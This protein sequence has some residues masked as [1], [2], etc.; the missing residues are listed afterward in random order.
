[1][2]PFPKQGDSNTLFLTSIFSLGS[3]RVALE[4]SYALGTGSSLEQSA[5]A[6]QHNPLPSAI[7]HHLHAQE[8][9]ITKAER[10]CS[11]G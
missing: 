1:M 11:H 7:F 5:K 8:G 4:A 9:S 10:A 2:A 6:L 3:L